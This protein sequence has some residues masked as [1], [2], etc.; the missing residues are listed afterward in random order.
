VNDGWSVGNSDELSMIQ[1]VLRI[2]RRL[3][4]DFHVQATSS[5]VANPQAVFIEICCLV[6]MKG[7]IRRFGMSANPKAA[8]GR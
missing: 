1:R 3:A 4:L 2:Q 7:R 6:L 5:L 8:K